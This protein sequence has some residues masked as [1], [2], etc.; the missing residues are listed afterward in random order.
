MKTIS[1]LKI[2]AVALIALTVFS[3]CR[4]DSEDK[5]NPN[6]MNYITFEQ[7]FDIVYNGILYS[8]IPL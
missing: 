7:Q 4:E 3:A 2:A 8:R 5:F 6:D 1:K